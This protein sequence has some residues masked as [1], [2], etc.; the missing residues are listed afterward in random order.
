MGYGFREFFFG[1]HVDLGS[2]HVTLEVVTCSVCTAHTL[3][4]PLGGRRGEEGREGRGGE[5]R[6]GV[7]C[8]FSLTNHTH[9]HTNTLAHT[10]THV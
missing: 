2:C 10:I 3:H 6:E 1:G 9:S 5:G 4:P 8:L 7:W